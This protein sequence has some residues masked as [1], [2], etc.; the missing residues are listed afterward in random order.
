M[1]TR[2][3]ELM[4]NAIAKAERKCYSP[5]KPVAECVHSQNSLIPPPR[6]LFSRRT[7][8]YNRYRSI[9]YSIIACF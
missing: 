6:D 4:E 5:H 9:S 3:M 2:E 1:V 7:A 8:C